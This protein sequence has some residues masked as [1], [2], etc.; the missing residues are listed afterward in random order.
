MKVFHLSKK[1][2]IIKWIKFS[3]NFDKIKRKETNEFLHTTLKIVEWVTETVRFVKS[4]KVFRE[5]TF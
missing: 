2:F 3:S 1:M 4:G 5:E